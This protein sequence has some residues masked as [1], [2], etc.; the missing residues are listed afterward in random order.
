MNSFESDIGDGIIPDKLPMHSAQSQ[1]KLIP[2]PWHKVRKQYIRKNQ[3]NLLVSRSI[4]R[5]WRHLKKLSEL[6]GLDTSTMQARDT[7]NCLVIPGDHLLDVRSL[8]NAISPHD[9]I[10]RYLGFNKSHGSNDK[11]TAIHIANNSVTSLPGIVTDSQ[12]VRDSFE[13]IANTTSQAYRYLKTYGPY[14]VVNLDMCNSMFPNKVATVSSCYKALKEL[15]T[16]QFATQ[17]MPWI[18]FITTMVEPGAMDEDGMRNLCKPT[19]ENL[20]EYVAFANEMATLV[21]RDAWGIDAAN[22]VNLSG[23][24]EEQLISLFG[25]AFGKWLLHLGQTASP[26]WS[27]RMR[28]SFRYS[29]NGD[30]GAVMLSLAFEMTPNFGPPIDSSGMT[31]SP[32]PVKT[33]PSEEQCAIRLAK[34]VAAINGHDVDFLLSQKPNINAQ[35]RD[36]AADLMESAGFDR[37]SYLAWVNS[38]EPG[39]QENFVQ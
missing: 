29:I 2:S 35:L 18:L 19:R 38:G 6:P 22:T 13:A 34:S 11:D 21:P 9:R 25:V 39:A 7:L 8:V 36:E 4:K 31:N 24:S 37:P 17:S 30:K 23:L 14:H 1:A 26:K 20:D 33:F 12:V 27:I 3:W 15:L 5:N 16:Y 28:P 10:I 32:S